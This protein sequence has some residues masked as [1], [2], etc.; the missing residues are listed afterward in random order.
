MSVRTWP[1]FL[2]ILVGAPPTYA[3]DSWHYRLTPYAWFAGLK[4][5][6]A[7]IP[8][9]PPAPIDISS[10]E[11]LSDSETSLMLIFDA[12]RGQHGFFTDFLYS[13]SRS[14]EE[15]IPSPI[16]LTLTSRTK[17][18]QFTLAYQYEIFNQEGAVV[19]LMAGARY[20]SIDTELTF[21]NGL[22]LLAG[23]TISNDESWLDPA[24][25]IKGRMPL[26]DTR[27][28]LEG[29]AGVGG[30]GIGSDLFYEVNTSVGYQWN[31]AI[32][33]A[34][35]YRMFDVDYEDDGYLYDVK[36]Q[37]WQLGLSWAF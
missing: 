35:G 36:Q 10:S 28:Y 24:L 18:T 20:W 13:D 22:G 7:T 8:G 33:T 15:L 6:V 1:L 5:T 17:T 30:F 16:N 32:G 31:N 26:G 14:D 29:G 23:K 27:F 21:G 3:D 2:V 19:D 12:K 11:A 9:A 4:G 37:G 34:L 25:G